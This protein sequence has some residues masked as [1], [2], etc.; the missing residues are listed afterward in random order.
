MPADEK[1]DISAPPRFRQIV[2]LWTLAA[3][4]M[5]LAG[6]LA[7]EVIYAE[8]LPIDEG[9]SQSFCVSTAFLTALARSTALPLPQ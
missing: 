3:T 2:L 7:L 8:P 5:V 6:G 4:A 9:P 1:K